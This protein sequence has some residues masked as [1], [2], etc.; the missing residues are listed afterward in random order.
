MNNL[1]RLTLSLII[2]TMVVVF[3][4]QIT[5]WF[6]LR[7]YLSNVELVY[8]ITA[9]VAGVLIF[10]GIKF[11]SKAKFIFSWVAYLIA[12]SQII[13]WCNLLTACANGDCL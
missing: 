10:K 1:L 11:N 12:M 6:E 8:I 9:I 3:G 4:V 5:Y 2:P 13:F 7:V